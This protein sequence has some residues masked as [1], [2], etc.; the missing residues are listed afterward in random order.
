MQKLTKLILT[1]GISLSSSFFNQGYSQ[2]QVNGKN[3]SK[4]YETTDD[5]GRTWTRYYNTDA[6]NPTIRTDE[7]SWQ[8]SGS[9]KSNNSY[10]YNKTYNSNKKNSGFEQGLL[11]GGATLSALWLINEISKPRNKPVI[12]YNYP[13]NN[14]QTNYNFTPK[15]N[16]DWWK[17]N[18][19]DRNWWEQETKKTESSNWWDEEEKNPYQL[20]SVKSL[21]DAL[22]E[23]QQ[24]KAESKI[25]SEKMSRELSDFAEKQVGLSQETKIWFDNNYKEADEFFK[26]FYKN[27]P[28]AYAE[29]QKFD[30]LH[31]IIAYQTYQHAKEDSRTGPVLEGIETYNEIKKD[32]IEVKEI[33]EIAEEKTAEKL[34]GGELMLKIDENFYEFMKDENGKNYWEEEYTEAEY[35]MPEDVKNFYDGEMKEAREF[36]S[37]TNKIKARPNEEELEKILN[38][39][40]NLPQKIGV[41][42]E[43]NVDETTSD[44]AKLIYYESCKLIATIDPTFMGEIFKISKELKYEE[45]Q[46]WWEK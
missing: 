19:S 28:K 31:K 34:P 5:Q 18:N 1:G 13:S 30:K 16:V 36:Y 29:T 45:K 44:I 38:T 8:I 7:T 4:K 14:P 17:E 10:N 32:G 20:K 37:E 23:Q 15:D 33:A 41:N 46:N 6:K 40:V 27:D 25:K 22:N 11:I 39:E 9:Q 2:Y 35:K 24:K 3:Y 21:D 43:K 12:N 26:D 42:R